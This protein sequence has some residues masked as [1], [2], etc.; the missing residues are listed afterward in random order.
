MTTIIT[1]HG[2]TG[3]P[4]EMN[5]LGEFLAERGIA[6][7][8]LQLPGHGTNPEDLKSTSMQDWINYVAEQVSQVLQTDE[9]VFFCGLSMGGI[10]TL[11]A[12]EHFPELKGGITLSAP[13]RILNL[14]QSLLTKLSFINFW[15]KRSEQDIRDIYDKEAAKHHRAYDTFHTSTVRELNKLVTTVRNNLSKVIQPCLVI[16]SSKDRSVSLKNADEIL[17]NISSKKKD[18][19]VVNNS[20]HVLTRDF[21]REEIFTRIYSFISDISSE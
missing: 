15:V 9:H 21:D 1:C 7:I 6:W 8:N 13:M 19:M 4:E 20:G 5:P 12:L 2:F 3:Y 14:W 11:Y 18:K 17:A 10:L 16:H